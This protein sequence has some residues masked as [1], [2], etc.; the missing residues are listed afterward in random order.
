MRNICLILSLILFVTISFSNTASA[1][2]REP[3]PDDGDFTITSVQGDET[4]EEGNENEARITLL[5]TR[6][7]VSTRAAQLKTKLENFKNKQ[8]A[9]KA[10]RVNNLLTQINETRLGN[11][12][13]QLD[14]M[15][16]LID[17]VE[18]RAKARNNYDTDESTTSAKVLVQNAKDSIQKAKTA[19]KAQSEKDFAIELT[20]EVNAK[21]DA[22]NAR[23]QLFNDLKNI[24]NL[25]I[26]AKQ[27]ISKAIVVVAQVN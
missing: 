1:V 7:K 21:R 6:E 18:T 24:L 4:I 14:R 16:V 2:L 19:V 22:Q 9:E 12:S 8:R 25:M 13:K 17:K 3:Q 20:T 11:F 10:E 27:S 5:N 23:T 26:E 15:D